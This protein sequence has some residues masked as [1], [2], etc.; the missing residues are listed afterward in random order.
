LFT[1]RAFLRPPSDKLV[2]QPSPKPI[3]A[4]GAGLKAGYAECRFCHLGLPVEL[5]ASLAVMKNPKYLSA[6][7]K[8][9]C[10][11]AESSC[12]RAAA[13]VGAMT[14]NGTA[15]GHADTV[16]APACSD[17]QRYAGV[18]RPYTVSACAAC[19]AP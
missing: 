4:V 1:S 5:P 8:L 12:K 3:G 11:Q 9:G 6:L 10:S 17:P 15:N 13:R 16:K 2:V 18:T 19:L 7:H 14:S